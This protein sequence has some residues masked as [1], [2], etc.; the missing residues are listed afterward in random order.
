MTPNGTTRHEMS[1]FPSATHVSCA[2]H[3]TQRL[4]GARLGGRRGAGR[5][6]PQGT[7]STDMTPTPI[8]PHRE[9]AAATSV[10]TPSDATTLWHSPAPLMVRG[11]Q[12][13]TEPLG[14]SDLPADLGEHPT[15]LD[16][17]TGYCRV[18]E[19]PSTGHPCLDAEAMAFGSNGDVHP[20]NRGRVA[21]IA[22][23]DRDHGHS[24]RSGFPRVA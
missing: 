13:G 15:D 1:P 12:D 21:G 8:H 16:P 11:A 24:F 17:R 23:E 9:R 19:G 10:V 4:V 22:G 14:G 7:P 3:D 20:R 18:G 5:Q 6:V 2:L